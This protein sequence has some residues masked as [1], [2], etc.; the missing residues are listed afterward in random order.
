MGGRILKAKDIKGLIIL[1]FSVF[2]VFFVR[3]DKLPILLAA[4]SLFLVLLS[5]YLRD[6]KYSR[7]I[8][9]IILCLINV[10]TLIFMI[11]YLLGGGPKTD[12]FDKVF[13]PFMGNGREIIYIG[14]LF[15]LSTGLLLLEKT[16]GGSS[17]R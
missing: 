5:F 7:H 9:L 17:G 12:L 16:G 3:A 8:F 2:S 1:I 14:W 10:F 13:R 4:I 11:Q 15:I 6:S